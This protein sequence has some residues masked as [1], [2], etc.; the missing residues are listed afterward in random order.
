MVRIGH[1]DD[2]RG[3][4]FS[5]VDHLIA[6]LR[7]V[8]GLRPSEGALRIGLLRFVGHDQDDLAVHI[9]AR[10]VVI[11]EL[12]R[13]DPITCK[14]SIAT[15]LPPCREAEGLEHNPDLIL[16]AASRKVECQAIAGRKPYTCSHFE[17]LEV[18]ATIPEW[19]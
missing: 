2:P 7:V 10:I 12:R 8:K 16:L 9:E 18:I 17:E 13:R 3:T 6:D 5:R 1:N 15:R 4:M 11:V 14:H 19:L